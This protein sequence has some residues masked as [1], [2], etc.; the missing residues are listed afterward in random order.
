MKCIDR[1]EQESQGSTC[2]L[3]QIPFLCLLGSYSRCLCLFHRKSHLL[4]SPRIL[5]EI[6]IVISL[7]FNYRK[8][9]HLRRSL[10]VYRLVH[11]PV[12]CVVRAKAGF[13]SQTESQY[14]RCGIIFFICLGESIPVLSIGLYPVYPESCVWSGVHD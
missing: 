7:S 12:I 3:G 6:S 14:G 9:V 8:F 4:F 10:F 5:A 1:R 11:A 2:R 13:D